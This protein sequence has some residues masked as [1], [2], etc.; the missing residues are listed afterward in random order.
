MI[1]NNASVAHLNELITAVSAA[2][3]AS[4]DAAALAEVIDGLEEIKE[5]KLATVLAN[6]R[7][8]LFMNIRRTLLESQAANP[9]FT[10]ADVKEVVSAVMTDL[11]DGD[12]DLDAVLAGTLTD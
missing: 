4:G 7:H 6:A 10:A 12:I 1:F 5:A 11:L 2:T 3:P 9:D 8:Y